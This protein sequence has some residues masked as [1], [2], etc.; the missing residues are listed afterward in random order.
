MFSYL[1]DLSLKI[2]TKKAKKKSLFGQ[3]F[4]FLGQK[5]KN[6]QK[7]EINQKS[8]KTFPK[9]MYLNGFGKFLVIFV[10]KMFSLPLTVKKFWPKKSLF[11]NFSKNK[12]FSQKSDDWIDFLW[13]FLFKNVYFYILYFISFQVMSKT[14]FTKT[15]NFARVAPSLRQDFINQTQ[16]LT[17]DENHRID[18]HHDSKHIILVKIKADLREESADLFLGNFDGQKSAFILKENT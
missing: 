18:S 4:S 14:I 11:G 9:H 5:S 6:F 1:F 12:N 15:Y 3:N 17:L 8:E 13:N 2:L 10:K 16:G 7:Y